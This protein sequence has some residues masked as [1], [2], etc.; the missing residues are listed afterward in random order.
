MA[1]QVGA[2]DTEATVKNE[3]TGRWRQSK[4]DGN[5]VIGATGMLVQAK[6]MK[7]GVEVASIVGS[8]DFE[9]DGNWRGY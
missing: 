1:E 4:H 2:E 3:V 6:W 9:A 7:G 5:G 8:G